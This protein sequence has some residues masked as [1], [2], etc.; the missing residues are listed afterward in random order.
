MPARKRRSNRLTVDQLEVKRDLHERELNQPV[1]LIGFGQDHLVWFD[2]AFRSVSLKIALRMVRDEEAERFS[3]ETPNG[4]IVLFRETKP[5]KD[6]KYSLPTLL[7]AASAEA[8]ASYSI[9]AKM[10]G[11]DRRRAEHAIVYPFIGDTKS[12]LVMPR[13][14][15]RDRNAAAQLLGEGMR[16]ST[17]GHCYRKAA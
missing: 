10:C 14:S 4:T 17:A 15:D 12:P 6:V 16:P 9:G 8:L 13:V 7:N 5:V 1:V 11:R 2:S 3:A